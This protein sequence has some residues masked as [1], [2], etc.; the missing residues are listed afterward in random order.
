MTKKKIDIPKTT[1]DDKRK[2]DDKDISK[3]Y[4]DSASREHRQSVPNSPEKP[5]N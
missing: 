5:Y 2:Q 3:D 4:K 1:S